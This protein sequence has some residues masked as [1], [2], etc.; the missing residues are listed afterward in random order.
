MKRIKLP[1][2]SLVEPEESRG[3]EGFIDEGDV[4][5]HGMPVTAPPSLGQQLP[6]H[7]GELT[8]TDADEDQAE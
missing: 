4:E 6:S 2:D 8:P 7:G 3:P 5:G 1:K